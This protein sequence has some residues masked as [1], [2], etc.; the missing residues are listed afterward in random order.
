MDARYVSAIMGLAGVTI[1]GATTFATSY[2]LQ[3]AQLRQQG[4][5]R[6]RARRD[7]LFGDFIAEASRLYAD[8][9][10]HEKDDV[11]EL[12]RLYALIARMRLMSSGEVVTAAERALDRIIETYLTP[13][14]GLH[15]LIGV[16]R[17]G[18][19][20][21]LRDF[22]EACRSDLAALD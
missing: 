20:N 16:A 15:D 13:N 4:R 6:E 14:R 3:R 7:S 21:F 18:E 5:H 2:V 19:I 1:G 11:A 9:L 17:R 10:G 8:A 22:A 12:V